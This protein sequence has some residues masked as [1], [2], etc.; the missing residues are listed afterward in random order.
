MGIASLD[1]SFRPEEI[2]HLTAVMQK[3]RMV[4]SEQALADY[5]KVITSAHGKDVGGDDRLLALAKQKRNKEG[6]G[7]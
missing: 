1:E 4:I 5:I 2:S 3:E 7:G 6:Y